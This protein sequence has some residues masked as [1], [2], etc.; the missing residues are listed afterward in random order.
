[1]RPTLLAAI[2][3]KERQMDEEVNLK[4]EK[5]PP[6]PNLVTITVK[7]KL[8]KVAVVKRQGKA[9]LVERCLDGSLQR[10]TV[11]ASELIVGKTHED[12]RISEEVWNAGAPYG[13]DWENMIELVLTG[14][15][16]GRAW[17]A[18]GIWTAEDLREQWNRAQ[19]IVVKICNPA[20]VV[21]L[22]QTRR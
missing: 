5:K 7:P 21:V 19:M 20:L 16:V 1:M 4:V 10:R 14:A 9:V 17:K 12:I 3:Y 6:K 8:V 22:K 15:D 2:E 18:A 11:P 13:C